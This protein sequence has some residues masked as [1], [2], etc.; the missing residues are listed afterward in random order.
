MD[1][2]AKFQDIV[3]FAT[4]ADY[5]RTDFF[6]EDDSL[7]LATA[8]VNRG[9]VFA[10][11]MANFGHE[12][13]F[14]AA[15]DVRHIKELDL[16]SLSLDELPTLPTRHVKNHLDIEDIVPDN[17][18]ILQ[19][20]DQDILGWL[21]SFYRRSRGFELGTFDSSLVATSMKRQAR[22]WRD[23]A[24]G[25]VSDV[26]TLVHCFVVAL[27]QHIV[28]G[29]RHVR[30]GV[31]SLLFDQLRRRYENALKHTDF[32]LAVELEGTPATY[33]HYF[34]DTL[35]KRYESLLKVGCGHC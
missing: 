9:E 33:N 15:E 14:D 25:Y 23:L 12:I 24:L 29:H 4:R 32:L 18:E 30:D 17:A 2:A 26:I 8:T 3:A 13:N 27:L 21:K 7:R 20:H 10:E 1:I 16:D 5:G 34:R 6:N 19:P 11:D 35:D 31:A 22:K 28:P